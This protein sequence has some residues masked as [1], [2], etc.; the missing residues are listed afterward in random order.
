MQHGVLPPDTLS[1]AI[2]RLDGAV[3]FFTLND[4]RLA[5]FQGGEETSAP[6]VAAARRK[7]DDPDRPM[8][9]GR[10]GYQRL[11]AK[12]LQI[13]ADAHAPAS[14][15]WSVTACAQPLALEILAGT[16]RLITGSGWTPAA[17]A[18]P[19]V[20]LSDA[21]S[22]AV[23]GETSVGE[24]IGGFPARA[25]GPRLVGAWAKVETRR[26]ETEGRLWLEMINDGWAERFGLRHER[27][28]S[29]TSP[30]TNF[31]ARTP[32]WRSGPNRGR[33]VAASS[34]SSCISTWL[35]T[36]APWRLATAR[37]C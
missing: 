15:A 14:G 31:A 20:R 25:L 9:V 8:P 21:A 16:R 23:L 3:R 24:P 30:P 26:Q 11:D 37:A 33:T 6:Y 29:S 28:C 36:S 32:S 17:Q 18:P 2:D 12:T 27:R 35:P 22:T 10:N 13:M 5:C 1:R 7:D 4:G 19:A 34:P